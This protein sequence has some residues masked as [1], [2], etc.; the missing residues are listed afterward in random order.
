MIYNKYSDWSD[1]FW[2]D[3]PELFDRYL[4]EFDTLQL[5]DAVR[6]SDLIEEVLSSHKDVVEK[7]LN[8]QVSVKGFLMEQIMKASKGRANPNIVNSTLDDHLLS[9]ESSRAKEEGFIGEE[10]SLKLLKLKPETEEKK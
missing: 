4:E 6:I 1:Q 8:G 5:D 9:I 3:H 2:K 7:Y 10:A